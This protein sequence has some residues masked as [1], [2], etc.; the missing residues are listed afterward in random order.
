MSLCCFS[1][2][3]ADVTRLETDVEVP[4]KCL[5]KE[6]NSE[7]ETSNDTFTMEDNSHDSICVRKNPEYEN[8]VNAMESEYEIE[9]I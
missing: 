2:S 9:T 1:H 6:T 3:T 8:L 5:H 7:T 4:V